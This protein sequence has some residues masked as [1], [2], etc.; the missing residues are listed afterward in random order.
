MLAPAWEVHATRLA[1]CDGDEAVLACVLDIVSKESIDTN[2]QADVI[3]GRDTRPSSPALAATVVAGAKAMHAIVQEAGV[4][5]TPQLHFAVWRQLDGW[6]EAYRQRLWAAL[7]TLTEG[8]PLL[9]RARRSLLFSAP[10]PCQ[11]ACGVRHQC[12][13]CGCASA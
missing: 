5:T 10:L 9:A 8:V 11:V 7:N 1:Q 4:C 12:C 13:G 3:V 6:K 2:I